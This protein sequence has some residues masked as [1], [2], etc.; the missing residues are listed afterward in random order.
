VHAKVSGS[1]HIPKIEERRQ[2]KADHYT[3]PAENAITDWRYYSRIRA[4]P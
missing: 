1:R 2:P 4:G 3:D